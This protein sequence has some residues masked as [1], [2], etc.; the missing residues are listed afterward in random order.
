MTIHSNFTPKNGSRQ[1]VTASNTSAAITIGV[2]CKTLRVKNTG[3]TN[4]VAVRT[5][6][7]SD[8]TVT[9]D[10]NKDLNLYPGEVIYI[11]KPQ[12]HDTL[13]YVSASGATLEVIAGE[14]GMGSGS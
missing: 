7:A 8:G 10:A 9:A 2:G 14:G 12:D 3:A 4:P 11:A 5:G 6:V 1:N 13:A